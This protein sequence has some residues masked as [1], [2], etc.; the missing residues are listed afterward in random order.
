MWLICW[1]YFPYKSPVSGGGGYLSFF[2]FAAV[3]IKAPQQYYPSY[4]NGKT[5][6]T[7]HFQLTI[8]IHVFTS[9]PSNFVWLCFLHILMNSMD[10]F[11]H[12]TFL[13]T[14]WRVLDIIFISNIIWFA[15]S[16][17]LFPQFFFILFPSSLI[18][19]G[20]FHFLQWLFLIFFSLG[21]WWF[22]L[23]YLSPFLLFGM[24]FGVFLILFY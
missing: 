3:R 10:W 21:Y 12:V 6:I 22:C 20:Q 4:C 11:F 5:K 1:T 24:A 19:I 23:S 9:N 18:C 7:G 14:H 15:F 8:E 13:I 17:I 16:L 2:R